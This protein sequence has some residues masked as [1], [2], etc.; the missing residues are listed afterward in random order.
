MCLT[1]SGHVHIFIRYIVLCLASFWLLDGTAAAQTAGSQPPPKKAKNEDQVI[2]QIHARL[3]AWFKKADINNDGFLDSAE[4]TNSLGTGARA[5]DFRKK[6]TDGDKKVS[7]DEFE[8]WVTEFAPKYAEQLAKE[9]QEREQQ[10]KKLQEA[11]AKANAQNKQRAEQAVRQQRDRMARERR[12]D[13][14]EQRIR[15]ELARRRR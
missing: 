11:A 10:L 6:D 4:I 8:A 1:E 15:N 9:E 12:E 3:M 13:Q 2:A 14:I 5:T 7:T